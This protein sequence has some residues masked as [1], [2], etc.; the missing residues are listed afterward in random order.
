MKDTKTDILEFWFSETKPA[1]W[2]LK[3]PDFDQTIRDRFSG[4]YDLG[5]AGIFD[6]WQDEAEGCL[7]LCILLDQ[8][9]RNMFR[10]APRAFATDHKS[11]GFAKH[12]LGKK[13]DALLPP[14]KRS[15][16]YM[17]FMHS[18]DPADQ[19]KSVEVFGSMKKDNPMGYDYALRHQKVIERFGRFPH[20]NAILGRQS[21]P[22]ELSYLNEPGAGF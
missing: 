14:Q 11:L 7:A 10:D 2:F 15:F 22:E 13:F 3:N 18:E 9:P 1:Q 5:A 8:F 6:G 17:P 16:L 4:D 20:R 19:A 12:A 21:T